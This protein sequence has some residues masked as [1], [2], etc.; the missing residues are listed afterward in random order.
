MNQRQNLQRQL[1]NVMIGLFNKRYHVAILDTDA[2]NIQKVISS[3][4]S[5]YHDNVVIKTY[6][7]SQSLFEAISINNIKHKPFDMAVLSNVDNKAE[8]LVLKHS[9]PDL[10]V[11]LYTDD[12]TDYTVNLTQFS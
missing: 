6:H 11:I 9:N 8:Q 12:K 10:R 1:I 4:K 5:W 3:I 2:E 7:T